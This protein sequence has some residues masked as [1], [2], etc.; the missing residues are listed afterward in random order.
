[1][2]KYDIAELDDIKLLVN[3]FYDEV[4]KDALIGPIFDE[5]INDRWP[6]HLEK[7]YRF[8]QTILLD[9]RT[10][11]GAPFPPH[12]DLPV[13]SEHF[14]TWLRL[15]NKTIDQLFSGPRADEAKWRADK[16]AVMFQHKIAYYKQHGGKS[17]L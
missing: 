13:D 11:Y 9:E 6:I 5:K 17:L 16:M 7:M 3:S 12:A 14:K 10:Y 8:W 15:F 2:E 1:M 4:R